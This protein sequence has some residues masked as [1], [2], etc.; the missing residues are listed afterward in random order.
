M[1]DDSRAS[2]PA[3]AA[4]DAFGR[5]VLDPTKNVL[6]LVAAAILRQDD[7]RKMEAANSLRMAELRHVHQDQVASLR[8]AYDD[9]LREAE[10]ARIDAIRAVDVNNVATAAA[11]S[12]ATASTLASQVAA[13]AEALRNQVAAAAQ[14]QTV[15][16]AAA[17]EPVQKDI[18][19]LRKAQY[20]QQGSKAQVVESRDVSGSRGQNVGLWIGAAVGILG[21]LL[22]VATVIIA[23]S[24]K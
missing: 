11:A 3:G 9:K 18:Q 8:A 19:D 4:T 13:S 20:E 5:A 14:A 7:L 17:L 15:A 16:L 12:A 22:A 24:V 10:S 21:F 6:D 1:A 23:V 2:A